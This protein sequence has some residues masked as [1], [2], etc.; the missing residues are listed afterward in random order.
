MEKQAAPKMPDHVFINGGSGMLDCLNHNLTMGN[1][2]GWATRPSV[3]FV[4][5]V[6]WWAIWSF[7]FSQAINTVIAR[8]RLMAI[9]SRL[10]VCMMVCLWDGAK[11]SNC[12]GCVNTENGLPYGWYLAFCG[13]LGNL[14]DACSTQTFASGPGDPGWHC[15]HLLADIFA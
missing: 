2:M 1:P 3:V 7:C 14:R 5:V 10:L 15:A 9:H 12:W 11:L 8:D 13:D 4:F 6:D